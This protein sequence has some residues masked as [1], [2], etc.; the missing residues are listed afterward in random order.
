MEGRRMCSCHPRGAGLPTDPG[1]YRN[2]YGRRADPWE[3]TLGRLREIGAVRLV[4]ETGF[5]RSAAIRGFWPGRDRINGIG[6]V[7]KKSPGD[8]LAFNGPEML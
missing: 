3:R 8:R 4:E 6:D 7:T 2:E 1:E 5:S